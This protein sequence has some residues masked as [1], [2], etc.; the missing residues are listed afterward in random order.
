ML[1]VGDGHQ[2]CQ[3]GDTRDHYR[4]LE[5][6]AKSI[7]TV[8][9]IDYRWSAEDAMPIDRVPFIGR[10]SPDHPHVYVATGF[11]KWGMSNGTAA[12]MILADMIQGRENPWKEIFDPSRQVP[13]PPPRKN[14]KKESK[15]ALPHDAGRLAL[16]AGAI[17]AIDGKETAAYRDAQG[18]VHLL[19]PAADTW[20][21]GLLERGRT[22]L[23][24]PC[25]GSRYT[26]DGAIIDGPTVRPPRESKNRI[27]SF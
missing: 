5:E 7:Y 16:N 12:A 15:E 6:F 1:V 9:S 4:H 2:T 25:H 10:I 19:D 21:P 17:M 18:S 20:L 3:G 14:S 13:E 11:R 24:L 8:R 26:P 22:E 27:I 23:G